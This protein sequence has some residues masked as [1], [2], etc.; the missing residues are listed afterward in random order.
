MADCV[1]TG[2]NNTEHE[3]PAFSGEGPAIFLP[4]EKR[5]TPNSQSVNAA[6]GSPRGT[7]FHACTHCGKAFHLKSSLNKHKK[8]HLKMPRNLKVV[9]KIVSQKAKKAISQPRHKGAL[10]Q[11]ESSQRREQSYL[12][13]YCGKSLSCR[14][15]LKSHLRIHT[16]E[17]PYVCSTCGRGFTQSSALTVHKRLHTGERP[18]LCFVCGKSCISSGTLLVHSRIHTGD[19][20][21]SCEICG[22]K[23]TQMSGLVAHRIY[24]TN[25]RPYTCTVCDKKHRTNN[26]LKR[27]MRIHTGDKPFEC[28]Q[29]GKRFTQKFNMRIHQRVHK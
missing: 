3:V 4:Q 26:A 13:S 5:L 23:F 8:T 28:P 2:N 11:C 9:S 14:S 20:P 25:D 27:H 17:Q 7:P 15:T 10:V 19:C 16:G 22:K 21:Y 24:H 18:Y 29:C 1:N 12:C 6:I